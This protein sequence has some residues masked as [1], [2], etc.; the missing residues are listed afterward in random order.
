MAVADI[1]SRIPGLWRS[2]RMPLLTNTAIALGL[3]LLN[4]L[5]D[6]RS[7]GR[8]LLSY[9]AYY[10]VFSHVIG[11]L[12]SLTIPRL[13][14]RIWNMPAW[15]MWPLFL[16][17]LVTVAVTGTLLAMTIL[18]LLG[19]VSSAFFVKR[20]ASSMQI[21]TIVTLIVGVASYVIESMRG[22]LEHTTVELKQQQLERERAQKLAAEARFSSLQSRLQPHFLFNTIN[23]VTSLIREDPRAAEE[24]L[25]RLSRLL[26]FA[27]DSQQRSLVPLG[28]E[29]KLVGDYLEIERTRFGARLR[30]Q[31]DVRPEALECE[32]PPYAVQTLVENSMKY[33]VSQRREGGSIQVRAWRENGSLGLEVRDDGAGF[34]RDD[35][36]DGHGL[37]TL[38]KRMLLL[39]GESASLEIESG[40]GCVVRLRI[41]GGV[42]A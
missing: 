25:L 13:A 39:Y 4:F 22:R 17:G 31:I 11:G 7:A 37:D 41:P 27:L 21:S 29:L 19:V 9:A 16:A 23:S 35:L 24:M 20:L 2:V 8:D 5:F 6:A 33:V 26:R 28:E 34:T 30:F 18:W 3:L 36:A 42:A 14:I 10:L 1:L 12:A 38:E 32:I 15:R 40:K